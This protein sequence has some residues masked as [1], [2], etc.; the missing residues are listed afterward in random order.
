MFEIRKE[1]LA[2]AEGPN[3]LVVDGETDTL[4][5]INE[6]LR[7]EGYL[8]S[9]A[10]SAHKA[11]QKLKGKEFE[12]IISEI[13][14]PDM[15]PVE[16]LRRVRRISL[17]TRVIFLTDFANVQLTLELIKEGVYDYLKKPFLK[18]ELKILVRKAL[19]KGEAF[20]EG[21]KSALEIRGK[22]DRFIIGKS[23]EMRKV[24]AIIRKI[25]K[26]DLTV[27]IQGETGTGKELIASTIHN[28][29]WRKNKTF[30][31]I[32]CAALSDSLL[33]SELFGYEKGAFTGATS[34]KQGLFSAAEAGT[35][36]LDEIS[37]TSLELQAKLLR[38][39]ENREFIRVGGTKP[40]KVNVRIIASTN[41]NLKKC[42]EE[43]K[44]R[45]D[46]YYRLNVFPI[47]VPPL[48]ER[49]E[50]IPLLIRYFLQR[51]GQYSNVKI[52]PKAV[53]CLLKYEW[54][55]NVR[56]LK[57]VILRAAVLCGNS[58]KIIPEHL[59]EYIRKL[60]KSPFPQSFFENLPFREARK[61]AIEAFERKY[62]QDLLYKN[63]GNVSR[64]SKLARLSRPYLHQMMKKYSIRAQ[65]YRN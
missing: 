25:A 15:G 12:V 61:R 24:F 26:T 41:R 51:S 3:I 64:A 10:Q 16:F 42:V 20:D 56:E 40:I 44:F 38:V 62:L 37:E 47:F 59:P 46:L 6:S 23:D 55:G 45:E 33:E 1:G 36:F 21:Q 60:K 58:K 65:D 27:L 4:N 34:T 49:K 8:F 28:L 63:K 18:D 53:E 48:R 9:T 17:R 19:Q 54:P 7:E 39:V 52:S 57:N 43:G 30:L 50:D 29:S 11:L 22:F 32:N 13:E 35:L 5:L 14:M 2:M 31:C